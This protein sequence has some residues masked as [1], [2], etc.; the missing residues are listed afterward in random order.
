MKPDLVAVT[1]DLIDHNDYIDWMP[2]TL[3]KL[4]G[5]CLWG[6]TSFLGNRDRRYG[7]LVSAAA[8]LVKI[9]GLADP[10]PV[11]WKRI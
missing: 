6:C 3:G 9:R 11:R 1:G 7:G 10:P 2:D 5:D 4:L 8:S